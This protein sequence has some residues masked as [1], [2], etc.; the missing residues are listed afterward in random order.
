MQGCS[1]VSLAEGGGKYSCFD[2]HRQF[3]PPKHPFRKDKKNFIKGKVVKNLAAPTMTGEHVLAQLN[4]LEP[5]PERPGYFKGYNS[6]HA[7]THKTC[8]WDIPY[9]QDLELPHNIDV[10][11]TEKKYRRGPVWYIFRHRWEVKG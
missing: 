5:D 11:H 1:S 10:M 3:L 9:F 6:E 2:L 8:F 4:S 7:W